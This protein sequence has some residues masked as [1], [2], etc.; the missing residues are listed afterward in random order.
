MSQD[1]RVCR[2]NQS[3]TNDRDTS[4]VGSQSPI[5]TCTQDKQCTQNSIHINSQFCV[6][7]AKSKRKNVYTYQLINYYNIH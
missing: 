1:V 3:H 4:I 2:L 6:I 7:R 5:D